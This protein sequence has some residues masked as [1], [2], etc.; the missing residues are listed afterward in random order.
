MANKENPKTK[1]FM[2]MFRKR[3]QNKLTKCTQIYF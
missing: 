2:G 1:Y 3:K